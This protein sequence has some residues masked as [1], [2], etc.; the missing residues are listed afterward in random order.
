MKLHGD[1][2]R[3]WHGTTVQVI[4]PRLIVATEEQ[5]MQYFTEREKD[6]CTSP[7]RLPSCEKGARRSRTAAK[8]GEQP[9]DAITNLPLIDEL[10]SDPIPSLQ[11]K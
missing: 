3:S 7:L 11:I 1:Q 9:L 6:P 5:S 4:Q 10:A 8:R 2:I